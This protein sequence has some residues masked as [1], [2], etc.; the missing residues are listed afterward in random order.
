[1]VGHSELSFCDIASTLL[2]LGA[3]IIVSLCAVEYRLSKKK[4]CNCSERPA[5]PPL[6]L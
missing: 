3:A 4:S 2:L 6:P 5:P 1:M